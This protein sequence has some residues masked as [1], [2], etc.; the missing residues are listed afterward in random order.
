M[1]PHAVGS[2]LSATT[3]YR[4][5]F[6]PWSLSHTTIGGEPSSNNNNNNNNEVT[7][8]PSNTDNSE[9]KM[10]KGKVCIA[11]S[12]SHSGAPPHCPGMTTLAHE[13]TPWRQ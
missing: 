11:P 7:S 12:L 3:E 10:L 2:K 5:Q 9:G 8:G 6:V 4:N 13:F 1:A